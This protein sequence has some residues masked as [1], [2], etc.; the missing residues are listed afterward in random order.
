MITDEELIPLIC[1]A[2]LYFLG[3]KDDVN[4]KLF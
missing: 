2:P 1:V 3:K 4:L